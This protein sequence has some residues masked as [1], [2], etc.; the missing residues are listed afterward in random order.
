MT[1]H[2]T[3]DGVT[4]TPGL[5]VWTNEWRVGRVTDR[6]A[7]HDGWFDV[8]YPDGGGALQNGERMT[9]VLQHERAEDKIKRIEHQ[10][11]LTGPGGRH[12]ADGTAYLAFYD[13]NRTMGF[14]WNG[15]LSLPVHVMREMGEPIEWAFFMDLPDGL[16]PTQLLLRFQNACEAFQPE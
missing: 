9:T 13:R 4:I 14:A 7:T 6:E 10:V 2:K 8:R 11:S 16:S 5:A 12:D 3:T 1:E 15:D